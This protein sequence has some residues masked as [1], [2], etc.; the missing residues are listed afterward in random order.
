VGVLACILANCRN[1]SSKLLGPS[2]MASDTK[3]GA[4]ADDVNPLVPHSAQRHSPGEDALG[5]VSRSEWPK[6]IG[7]VLNSTVFQSHLLAARIAS[8]RA[9]WAFAQK[10]GASQLDNSTVYPAVNEAALHGLDRRLILWWRWASITNWSSIDEK[11]NREIVT[12]LFEILMNS[13]GEAIL[14]ANGHAIE[15]LCMAIRTA[16]LCCIDLLLDRVFGPDASFDCRC[17]DGD[18]PLHAAIGAN[19]L[20]LVTRFLPGTV[21][22]LNSQQMP[23]KLTAIIA[24]TFVCND[25][26]THALLCRLPALDLDLETSD[27]ETALNLAHDF[28]TGSLLVAAHKWMSQYSCVALEL[29]HEE[30]SDRLAVDL[31]SIITSYIHRTPIP[32]IHC[33]V[34]GNHSKSPPEPALIVRR[35]A[36]SVAARRTS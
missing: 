13:G 1:R 24:A 6:D 12:G 9:A 15:I 35:A 20:D 32:K 7:I 22:H 30:L 25:E 23:K 33:R 21:I 2:R 4:F 5:V 10:V 19:R 3:T 26:I 28:Q 36:T 18:T 29:L 27:G 17:V 8:Q 31:L 16:S 34:Q 11:E 14:R